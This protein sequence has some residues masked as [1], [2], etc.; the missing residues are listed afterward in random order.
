MIPREL[1]GWIGTDPIIENPKDGTLL[2]LIPEGSF[3]AGDENGPVRLPAY[4][5]S[6]HPVTNAQYKRFKTDWPRRDDHPVVNVNWGE[7]QDY[8][9]WAGLR[10]P[11]KME[12]EKGARGPGGHE[13]PWGNQWDQGK[14]RNQKNRGNEQTGPVW[15]YAAGCSPWGMYQMAGNVWEWC[16]DRYHLTL[17]STP[18]A[19]VARGN[20]WGGHDAHVFRCARQDPCGA[21]RRGDNLGF[22]PA[23]SLG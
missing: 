8:C 22:R 20:S 7:A 4:Y 12:W 13:Y 1:L 17:P 19:R 18:D 23:R 9:R 6:L 5:L 10:L 3:L 15:M 11:T 2:A 16:E 21:T 14:C